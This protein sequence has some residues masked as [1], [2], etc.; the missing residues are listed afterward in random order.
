MKCKKIMKKKTLPEKG[1]QKDGSFGI[2][3]FVSEI[4]K[5]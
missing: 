3:E 5:I 4:H 2:K 1:G